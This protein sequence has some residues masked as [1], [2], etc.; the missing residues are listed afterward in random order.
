M[1]NFVTTEVYL[2]EM[3]LEK[4]LQKLCQDKQTMLEIHNLF[5]KMMDPYVPFLEGPLSQ[6]LE[7]TDKGVK[8][9]Q[10][11]AHYQYTGEGFNFTKDDHP[12]AS[13]YWDKTMMA[14]KGDEFKQQ[15]KAIL[16]RRAK[17]IY[18]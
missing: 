3:G 4:E 14:Q 9:L 15:V 8:Y 10:P 13:A 2:D 11:Y 16:V 12:L 7:I 1:S 5:A 18:G 17:E 6:T